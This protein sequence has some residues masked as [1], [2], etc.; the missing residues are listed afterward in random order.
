MSILKILE[1]PN[2]RLRTKA[3]PIL[4]FDDALQAQINSMFDTMYYAPGVGLAATQVD[5]H[6]QLFVVD[7]SENKET[8]LV[9]V[10]PK[11][12]KKEGIEI[13]EEGCLSFPGIY[14]HVERAESLTIQALDRNGKSFTTTAN[15]FLAICIQHELDH[16][17]GKLFVDYLSP[18]K[19]DRIHKKLTKK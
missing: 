6:Y 13:K 8:P 7:V 11:I 3:K 17:Q 19:R 10:N 14:I 2:V 12:I 1:Y 4:H 18:L 9:F 16:L 15:D 5:Y